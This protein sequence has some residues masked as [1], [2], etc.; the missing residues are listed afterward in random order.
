MKK[1]EMITMEVLVPPLRIITIATLYLDLNGPLGRQ[2]PH[3]VDR[4]DHEGV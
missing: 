1:T 4:R 3:V 2:C